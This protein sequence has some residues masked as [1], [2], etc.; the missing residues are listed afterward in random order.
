MRRRRSRPGQ[1]WRARPAGEAVELGRRRS[2]AFAKRCAGKRAR[3][4]NRSPAQIP[5]TDKDA[6]RRARSSARRSPSP[7]VAGPGAVGDG[8]G[9]PFGRCALAL[10]KPPLGSEAQA[11][12][13]RR[14]SAEGAGDGEGYLGP[15]TKVTFIDVKGEAR[16]VEAQVGATVMETALHNSI[17]GIEAEVAAPALAR[18]AMF[19]STK[20]GPK[21]SASPRK[22]KRTCSISRSRCGRF[23]A[24]L[25]DQGEPGTG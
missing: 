22:W 7:N 14:Q 19:M 25:P 4:G 6:G 10:R 23:A 5:L 18:P 3:R 15:M 16:T 9:R 12:A 24:L 13:E 1:G 2:S 20:A 11:L 17:P 21:R 8:G